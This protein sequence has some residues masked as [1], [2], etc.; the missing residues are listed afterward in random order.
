VPK[1]APEPKTSQKKRSQATPKSKVQH[2]GQVIRD[3]KGRLSTIP[4]HEPEQSYRDNPLAPEG[5]E[6]VT[7][8]SEYERI[9]DAFFNGHFSLLILVGRPG[10]SKSWEFEQRI[11]KKKRGYCFVTA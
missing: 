9:A 6:V 4:E 10:L 3:A 5:A 8:F 11:S 1:K 7:T 2:I